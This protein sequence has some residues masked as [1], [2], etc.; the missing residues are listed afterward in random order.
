MREI[1]FRAWDGVDYMSKPFDLFAIQREEI[2]FTKDA[3]LMQY[4]GL[5]DKNG[6]E[7]YEGDIV[8]AYRP[9]EDWEEPDDVEKVYAVVVYDS[10][11]FY[12]KYLNEDLNKFVSGQNGFI[13][14]P[15]NTVIGNIYQHPELIKQLCQA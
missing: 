3:V 7:I 11:S 14:R 12:A 13:L 6:K 5:H 1:K 8:W 2:S 9:H 15:Y 4:T 10:P